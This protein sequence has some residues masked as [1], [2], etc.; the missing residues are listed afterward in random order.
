VTAPH[1]RRLV[2]LLLA[3][4]IPVL[5]VALVETGLRLVDYKGDLGLFQ[6]VAFL[7]GRYAVA[8]DRFPARYFAGVRD[9][10]TPPS[11]LFLDTKPAHGFRVFVLGESSAAGFPYSYN[12]T[13]SRVLQDA[14]QDVMPSQTVEV[15]NLGVAA[16]CSYSLYDEVDEILTRQPDA[17]VIYAGHNEFYGA[18]GAGSTAA[19]GAVPAFVR[20]YLGLQRQFKIVLLARDLATGVARGMARVIGFRPASTSMMHQMVGEELIL[21][22]GRTYRRGVQQFR[23]N[24]QA[25][26][27]RFQA[28]GVPVF[29]GSLTSNLRDQPPFR[30]VS[31]P[32]LPAADGV[33]AEARQALAGGAR[34]QARR[35]F[36]RA[37]DL[38]ALR[39]RAP[40]EFNEIIR[41]LSRQT[42]ARYVP[43]DEAFAKA[44]PDGIPG[45]ELFWEHLHPN[46][47]GYH[48]MAKTFFEAFA[49]AGFLGRT[50]DLARLK[51]WSVYYDRMELTDFDRR[52]A[53]HAIRLLTT[54]WPFVRIKD[55]DGY[56]KNYQPLDTVDS[57]AFEAVNRRDPIWPWAKFYLAG[58]YQTGAQLER[59]LA[60]YRGLMRDQPENAT[61]R[62][63]AADI[64]ERLH[65]PGH[66]RELLE[67]AYVLEPSAQTCY[68][69]GRYELRTAN[70]ARAIALLHQSLRYQA[71]N[72]AV[73]LSLSHAYLMVHQVQQAHAYADRLALVSPQ[74]P[75]LEELRAR[76]ATLPE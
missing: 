63:Y 29:V 8:N 4:S 53:W 7:E 23:D 58:Y 19:V 1:T 15:V 59:A 3:L 32:T 31:T 49:R 42:G 30:S 73:L 70:Y 16:I 56:P 37:R 20:T 9:V 67:R 74:F 40:S 50:T 52:Y 10:P 45:S 27:T 46:Q 5:A 51:S 68:A 55:P 69:L 43:V 64:Y 39:F 21:L 35:L 44:A 36:E 12:G 34:D 24:L 41:T 57:L 71:D 48:L 11:D 54:G 2:F 14:L 33:F 62:L 28:S 61:I 26:L 65:D 72:P 6:R 76:L 17:V 66:A 13:F 25:I 75:G 18:L 38:D 60:E 47:T 22:D